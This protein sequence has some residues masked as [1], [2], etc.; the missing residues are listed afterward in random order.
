MVGISARND[1]RTFTPADRLGTSVTSNPPSP[2]RRQ[3]GLA[4][5]FLRHDAW[6]VAATRT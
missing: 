1:Q 4:A 6:L 3:R 5:R 2:L